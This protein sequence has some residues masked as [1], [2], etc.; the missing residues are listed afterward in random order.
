MPCKQSR[1]SK[2]Q[3]VINHGPEVLLHHF[4]CMLVHHNQVHSDSGPPRCLK[5][6][7]LHPPHLYVTCKRTGEGPTFT[8]FHVQ[9]ALLMS[10]GLFSSIAT[11]SLH[12]SHMWGHPKQE[13]KHAQHPVNLKIWH[14]PQA[15]IWKVL[16]HGVN[17]RTFRVKDGHD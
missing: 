7:P 16:I 15:F 12:Q 14:N 1:G 17:N 11:P 10:W 8:L 13:I 3:F 5:E 9:C 2:T 4:K 6:S